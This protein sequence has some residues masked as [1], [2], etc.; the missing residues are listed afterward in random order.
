[1]WIFFIHRKDE[2]KSGDFLTVSERSMKKS[3]LLHLRFSFSFFLLPVFLLACAVSEHPN[4]PTLF[5]CFVI[6]HFLVYPASNGYNSYFDRDEKSI[7][8]LRNPPEVSIELYRVSLILD[9]I[10]L[11]LSLLVSIAFTVMIFIYGLVSKAYSHPSVRLKKYPVA[12]WLSAGVFQGYFTFLLCVIAIEDIPLHSTLSSRIQ[13]PG[14]LSTLLLLGSYPMTQVY[15]HEEDAGRGDLTM[16]R[17]LGVLGTFHFTALAFTVS[18]SG[19][20]YYFYTYFSLTKALLFPVFLLPI[21]IYF[22][23][24]YLRARNTPNAVNYDAAMRLNLIS[25]LMLSLYFLFL[26]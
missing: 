9:V 19:F 20:I 26:C 5:L 25:S 1:M 10:G 4:L 6:L 14:M 12:G 7:G 16:S 13:L 22:S 15:Q 24:W 2:A 23:V 8:G 21:L 17:K 11:G 3:T 18:I